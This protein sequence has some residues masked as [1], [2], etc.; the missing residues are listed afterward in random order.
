[1]IVEPAAH[2]DKRALVVVRRKRIVRTR[3]DPSTVVAGS[4]TRRHIGRLAVGEDAVREERLNRTRG[5]ATEPLLDLDPEEA[6]GSLRA[7]VRT[8][9]A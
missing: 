7:P 6:L 1:M 3:F 9:P 5:R 2:R 8:L 4:D